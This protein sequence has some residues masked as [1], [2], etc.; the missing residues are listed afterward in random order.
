MSNLPAGAEH[1][2]RAPWH[3]NHI[4]PDPSNCHCCQ[5]DFQDYDWEDL[6]LC[7]FAC[8]DSYILEKFNQLD[9]TNPED[10][11][12]ANEFL[13]LATEIQA[14]CLQEITNKLTSKHK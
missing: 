10:L 7:G 11:K 9:L 8:A 1:D 5:Q 4:T 12:A 13:V 14:E 6:E 3:D 2:P